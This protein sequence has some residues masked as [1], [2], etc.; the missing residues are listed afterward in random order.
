MLK[1]VQRP[2][3]L[4]TGRHGLHGHSITAIIKPRDHH[5]PLPV[6]HQLADK[7]MLTLLFIHKSKAQ[8]P[9]LLF[10]RRVV[11]S[12][13]PALCLSWSLTWA[14]LP[15]IGRKFNLKENTVT[16]MNLFL[17]HNCS[18]MLLSAKR[19]S[20]ILSLGHSTHYADFQPCHKEQVLLQEFAIKERPLFDLFNMRKALFFFLPSMIHCFLPFLSRHIENRFSIIVLL[21]HA[22]DR[23]TEWKSQRLIVPT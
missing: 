18:K 7:I 11:V 8:C 16:P 12:L 20:G 3:Q 17:W 2:Q 6:S 1:L 15:I 10:R 22:E 9:L 5:S 19:N 13:C 14:S 23:A 21:N 4:E